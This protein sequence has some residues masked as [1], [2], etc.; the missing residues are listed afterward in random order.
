MGLKDIDEK[1]NSGLSSIIDIFVGF[2]RT[3]R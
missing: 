1:E 3:S 2:L